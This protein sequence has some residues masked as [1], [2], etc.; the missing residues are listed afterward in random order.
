MANECASKN[1][2]N[3]LTHC[4]GKAVPSGLRQRVYFIAKSDIVTWPALPD[5]AER[6]MG[7][8]AAYKG[9]F[10]LASDKKWQAIDLVLNKGKIE[11]ESQGEHPARTYLNKLSLSSPIINEA[12][13][14][15]A[16]QA[17]SDYLVFLVQQRDGKFRVIG[18]AMYETDTKPKL[19]SGEGVAGDVGMMV[20]I[21]V[22]DIC[23]APFYP[24]EIEVEGGKISGAT[25][26]PIL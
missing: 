3:S 6:S 2:Y 1:L 10:V 20:E 26:L 5:T 7:E 21:E 12:A 17:N 16:R 13:T 11:C 8:L 9:N 18:N 24:G 15:F 25:G 19:S 14:G 4:P 22:T 23:P